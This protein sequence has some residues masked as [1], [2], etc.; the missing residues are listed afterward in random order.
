MQVDELVQLAASGSTKTIEGQWIAAVERDGVTADE[1]IALAPVLKTLIDQ[2]QK[3]LAGSLAWTAVEMFAE[4]PAPAD[5]L[6][7]GKKFLL[8][9]PRCDDLRSMVTSLYEKLYADQDGFESLTKIAGIAGGRPPRRAIRILDLCLALEPGAYALSRED[10]LAVRVEAIDKEDWQITLHDGTRQTDIDALQFADDYDP[11]EADDFRVLSRFD[12]PRLKTVLTKQPAQ[13]I[14]SILRIRDKSISSDELQSILTPEVIPLDDW[15]KWWTKARTA[16]K[17]V[18]EVSL[19]GRNPYILQYVANAQTY[20]G[21]IEAKFKALTCAA[22]QLDAFEKYLRECKSHKESPNTD[23]MTRLRVHVAERAARL[24]KSGASV[25]LG[26]RIVEWQIGSA[27]GDADA[28]RPT[29]DLL[30]NAADPENLVREC[31]SPA[32]WRH[33]YQALARALPDRSTDIFAALLPH[34]PVQTCAELA[35]QLN[36]DNL[37]A[38]RLEQIVQTILGDPISHY[39]AICW[40]WDGA[41]DAKG[42]QCVPPVTV[43]SRILWLLSEIK[44]ESKATAD[45]AKTINSAV[46]SVLSARKYERFSACGEQI[47]S[48]MAAALI[49][50]LQRIDGLGYSVRDDMV[51]RLRLQFPILTAKPTIPRWEQEEA[52]FSSPE[53]ISRFRAD[54]DELV[55]VKMKENAKAIGEAAAKGDLSENSEYKFALE[56]RDLLRARFALM[57]AQIAL[58]KPIEPSDVPNDHISIGSRVSFRHVETGATFEMTFLS[59]FD[60]DADRRIYNYKSPLAQEMMGAKIGNQFDLQIAEPAGLYEVKELNPWAD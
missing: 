46:K 43:L 22:D 18:P 58:A 12:R 23:L 60:A 1:T 33:A 53:G 26:E 36:K 54:I 57:S 30:S 6:R 49:T 34:A 11:C 28:D 48:G 32:L 50:Q 7:V 16:L 15:K 55:D 51:G 41:P 45:E 56:E 38:E 40:L 9:L 31:E 5:A 35:Q 42:W 24:Q 2:S 59:S 8:L 3:E 14:I 25:V 44:L 17:R 52:I 27:I 47:E 13:I 20:E 19:E 10:E 21:E 29:L 37:P 39:Q 4:R